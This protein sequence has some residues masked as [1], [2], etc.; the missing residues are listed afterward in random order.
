MSRRF[1]ASPAGTNDWRAQSACADADPDAM[2]PDSKALI[3]AA[4]DI[5]HHCP[6]LNDCLND[7][8]RNDEVQYGIR[9][10]LTPE[11]RRA[12]N[13]PPP[14]P[15]ATPALPATLA[16]AVALRTTVDDDAHTRWTGVKMISF[17]GKRYTAAQAAFTVGYGRDPEGPVRRSCDEDCF[18]AD[19][20]TDGAIRDSE[21]R[22]GTRPG[23]YQHRKRNEPACGPCNRANNDADRRLR[24]TGTTKAAA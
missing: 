5:C 20:L 16:E 10:G 7:A 11:E 24:A 22:C 23:Y 9:G 3:A 14:P 15:A 21:A 6:V 4:K 2:F 18:T 8:L 12:I 1:T 17:R 19:H 13:A